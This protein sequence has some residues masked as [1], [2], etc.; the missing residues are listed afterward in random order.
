MHVRT[1]THRRALAPTL[2]YTFQQT[3]L[4]S[5]PLI[6]FKALILKELSPEADS[7]QSEVMDE[8]PS[9][10]T[11]TPHCEDT[12]WCIS[13]HCRTSLGHC[14]VFGS[15]LLIAWLTAAP[16]GELDQMPHWSF[17]VVLIKLLKATT[18]WGCSLATFLSL[19]SSK[20]KPIIK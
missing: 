4:W 12:S 5:F 3:S 18:Q 9:R 10:C 8:S 13:E 16:L 17:F 20:W 7:V 11:L 6:Y 14:A 15:S 1:P 2:A 19:I